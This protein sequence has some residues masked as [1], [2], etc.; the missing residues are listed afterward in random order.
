MEKKYS[1]APL[2]SRGWY[3]GIKV[4][5]GVSFGCAVV[6]FALDALR[7]AQQREQPAPCSCEPDMLLD[8]R[9]VPYYYDTPVRSSVKDY[10]WF[11]VEPSPDNHL[12]ADAIAF[13]PVEAEG[14]MVMDP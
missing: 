9:G 1:N 2:S 11:Y 6:A 3:L 12:P 10:E 5:I 7:L 13:S 14:G 4:F 8:S